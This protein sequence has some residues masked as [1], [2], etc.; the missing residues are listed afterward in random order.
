MN[1]SKRVIVADDRVSIRSSLRLLLSQEPALPVIGD[2]ADAQGLLQLT[3]E[4]QPDL[5]LLD[6]ELP[7]LPL[8]QL[9]RLLRYEQPQLLI[10]AMSSRPE[11]RKLALDAGA[12]AFIDKTE[13]PEQVLKTIDLL[14]GKSQASTSSIRTDRHLHE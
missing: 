2:A 5:V 3:A 14:V 4:Q 12:D 9:I 10:V 8:F 11:S 7:G 13:T 6:W 1:T